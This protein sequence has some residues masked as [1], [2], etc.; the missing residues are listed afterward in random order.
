M[1]LNKKIVVG[2]AP[3]KRLFLS[4]DAASEQK[5]IFMKTIRGIF[6]EKIEI[7]DIDD[8]C[9][10]GIVSKLE[11]IPAIVGKF[12][13]HNIDAL[14]LPFCDFGEEAAAYGIAREFKIPVLIW[15]PR[16]NKPNTKMGRGRDT[17]CGIFAATKVLARANITYSY[18]INS[19]GDG[20]D[21]KRGF[22]KFVRVVSV[23]RMLKNLKVA[24]IGNRPNPF[25]SVI[26]NEA[27]LQ[28]KFGVEVIPLSLLTIIK[29]VNE[30]AEADT[31]AV[32]E[33]IASIKSRVDCSKMDTEHLK[34]VVSLKIVLKAM[35]EQ[36]GCTAA[37]IGCWAI[38]DSL[39]VATCFVN[40]ELT[41]L[42]IPVSCEMDINGAITSCI[43]QAAGLGEITFFAD[44][45]IRNPENDNSEL[46]WHC[47]PFPYSLKASD[48]KA[49][50]VGNGGGQW[51]LRD[52][53]MTVA[54]FDTI[55]GNY[56]IFAGNAKTT[57]G[58]ETV[59]TYVWIET[60]NW[61]RWEEKFIFGPYIHHI[62]GIYGD[63]VDVLKECCRYIPALDWDDLKDGPTSL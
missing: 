45:T 32:E 19:P 56:K 9:E 11:F 7:V 23:V 3:T 30:M 29:K 34:K 35:L 40:G 26:A 37:A 36:S 39:G 1:F 53:N 43:L 14:F 52:G 41:D 46:L 31:V 6:P 18:I 8:I 15:G 16:D 25:F 50:M 24:T 58:P 55:D 59:N 17:Q 27:E 4:I 62:S 38:P 54:R 63:Y 44:L 22:E 20:P 10:K 42:G 33:E 47:G 2:V 48:S 60:E 21:L 51:R 12:K 57:T 61:K 28:T 49:E 5:D 13:Q